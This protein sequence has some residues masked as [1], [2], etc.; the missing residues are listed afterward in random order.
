MADVEPTAN[1]IARAAIR[2]PGLCEK[3]A[4]SI[5]SPQTPGFDGGFDH[6]QRA[7]T[8]AKKLR[9]LTGSV[10]TK[11]VFSTTR[12]LSKKLSAITRT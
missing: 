4:A 9:C 2:C 8:I 12:A 3:R 7:E 5:A 10:T 6:A 1:A 11:S